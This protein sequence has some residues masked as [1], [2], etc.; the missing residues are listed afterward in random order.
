MFQ[1]YWFWYSRARILSVPAFPTNLSHFP[2]LM[3][4]MGDVLHDGFE[5]VVVIG[6]VVHDAFASVGFLQG[7][8][9]LHNISI[10]HFPVGF[11]ISGMGV[12]D[13]VFELV[14]GMG[15]GFL[16]VMAV[17]FSVVLGGD[18]DGQAGYQ[19][20]DL[21]WELCNIEFR[22]MEARVG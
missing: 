4:A 5:S 16:L 11:V 20:E 1:S 21:E 15:M 2:P 18:N 22:V 3:V 14:L 9:A 19:G 10:A 12:L 6:L 13:T 8:L 7:V 17:I